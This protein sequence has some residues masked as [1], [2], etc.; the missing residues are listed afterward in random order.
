MCPEM[1]LHDI[2]VTDFIRTVEKC[3]GD[4]FLRTAEGDCFNLKSRLSAIVG[5]AE[6]IKGG[7]IA[8]ATLQCELQE[9]ETKLFRFNLFR[10]VPKN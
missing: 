2:D 6:L 5:L 4:V 7:I 1:K 10:E 9:D 8:E 3:K